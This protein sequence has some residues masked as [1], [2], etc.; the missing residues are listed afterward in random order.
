MII[1]LLGPPGAGKGTQ[2]ERLA[3]R[4][5]VPKVATGDVLRA[6]VRDGTPLGLEAKA[7]MDRG[8]LV[9]DA[10]IMGIMRE[11][12]ASPTAANGAILDGVVRT[13]PQAQGL[14][15]ALA[16]LG[17][18]V[19]AVLLFEIDEDELVRRLS[20]RTTCD[21]CQR[22]FFGREPGETCSEGGQTGTLVRRKD[23]EPDAIRKRMQVYRDQTAPV[24]DWY[25]SHGANMVRV[26]ALG[27]LEDVEQRVL[28]AL[29]IA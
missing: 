24:I 11:A 4:L 2:G 14:T 12:L 17:R 28:T 8:D 5:D 15:D 9:P 23:D 3:A 27:S 13:T 10:V 6:A 19:D 16:A 21:V 1:V 7:A 29:G 20:G 25:A 26:D 18:K 22:P